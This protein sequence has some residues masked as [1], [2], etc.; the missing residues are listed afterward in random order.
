M[1]ANKRHREIPGEE[2]GG[3]RSRISKPLRE[4]IFRWI[5]LP[6]SEG[7]VTPEA[8]T[9]QRWEIR[10]SGLPEEKIIVWLGGACTAKVTLFWDEGIQCS[11][12]TTTTTLT[13]AGEWSFWLSDMQSPPSQADQPRKQHLRV[14]AVFDEGFSCGFNSPSFFV[15]ARSSSSG[16]EEEGKKPVSDGKEGKSGSPPIDSRTKL[17][18]ST[19][20]ISLYPHQECFVKQFRIVHRILPSRLMVYINDMNH[21]VPK[22]QICYRCD[23]GESLVVVLL[24]YWANFPKPLADILQSYQKGKIK[25]SGYMDLNYKIAVVYRESATSPLGSWIIPTSVRLHF[26]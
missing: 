17:L 15:V 13:Q 22:D 20:P 19:V 4:E 5:N 16:E 6:N 9:G 26:V 8:K 24:L 23:D 1:E 12:V 2:A 18:V 3:K 7:Y 21:R 11:T 25:G 10:G 14:E